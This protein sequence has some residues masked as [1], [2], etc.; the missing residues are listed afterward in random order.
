MKLAASFASRLVVWSTAL[1]VVT[2]ISAT[3]AASQQGKAAVTAIVGT[4][5]YSTNGGA[6]MVLKVGTV[7]RAGSQVITG[8]GSHVDLYLGKNNGVARVAESSEVDVVKLTYSDTGVDR[9]IDTEFNV[10]KGH[11]QIS[12]PDKMAPASKYEITTPKGMAGIRGTKFDIFVCRVIVIEGKVQF[13]LFD[14]GGKDVP[15]VVTPRTQY[16]CVTGLTHLSNEEVVL[17]EGEINSIVGV[18]G[19]EPIIEIPPI[20]PFLSPIK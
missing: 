8:G 12:A 20:E 19:P 18:T 6:F 10:R 16:D 15:F 14:P 17:L 3:Q 1:A 9:V 13:V 2:V 5:E 7:L 4:A 11:M